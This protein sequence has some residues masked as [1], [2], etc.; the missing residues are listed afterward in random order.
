MTHDCIDLL[1]S[2]LGMARM[3]YPDVIR[4][5]YYENTHENPYLRPMLRIEIYLLS[6]ILSSSANKKLP[7]I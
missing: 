6:P 1:R 2:L 3:V 4:C 5:F 7:V